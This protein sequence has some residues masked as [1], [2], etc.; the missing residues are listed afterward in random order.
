MLLRRLM[1]HLPIGAEFSRANYI[2]GIVYFER[3]LPSEPNK[4]GIKGEKT[5]RLASFA[6]IPIERS[7]RITRE[8]HKR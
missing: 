1:F 6:T 4:V 3:I 5:T 8:G 7:G 2:L